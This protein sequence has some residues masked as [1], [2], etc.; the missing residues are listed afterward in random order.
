MNDNGNRGAV[1]GAVGRRFL[2]AVGAGRFNDSGI[3]ALPGVEDD[4][5]RVRALLEKMGYESVLT[6]LAHDPT[7]QDLAAG[8]E[9]WTRRAGLG[10]ED[11]VVVY[12]AGHGECEEDRHYLLCSDSQRDSWAWSLAAEDLARRLVHSEVGHLLVMLDTCFAQAGTTD[13]SRLAMSLAD[14][15]VGRANR[16][17]L[18][19]A[20]TTD[21]AKENLF[22]D[23][24]TE[25]F[26]QPRLG[27]TPPYIGLGEVTRRINAYFEVHRPSQ[28]ARLTA[29]DTDGQDPFFL[30]RHHVP[31]LP[32]D[33]IDLATIA[34][35]RRR[36][37]G[38]F[39]PRS[40]GVEHTGER[41]DYFTGRDRALRELT[42]FLTTP[43]SEHD[44]KARVVTGDP[45][46]GKSALLGRLLQ[47]TD[48]DTPRATT[49]ADKDTG[50]GEGTAPPLAVA[51]VV[52][53]ARR[54]ALGDLV[55]DLASALTLPATADRDDVLAALGERTVPVAVVVDSLDEA[56]TA[57][58]PAESNRIARELLQPLSGLP[59]VRLVVGTRRPQIQALGRAVHV[60]DL[61]HR[62]HIAVGEIAAYARALLEDAQDP[63]S[64]SPY[65]NQPLLAATIAYGIAQRAG[66]S[67][68]VARM[69]ARALVHG[70][71]HIDTTIPDWR[72]QLPS[73]ASEA[74]AAYL[75]RFEG[76]RP[77]VERLLRP[78]AY[79]QGAGLPWSTLWA[80]LAT[81][82][83]GVTCTHEDLDWLHSTAGAYIVETPTADGAVFRLYH[84]TMAEHL[85]RTGHEHHDHAT[86]A[87]TLTNLIPHDPTTGINDWAT[88][89]PYSR[90]HLATHAAAGGTLETLLDD[91]E[92]LVHADPHT[93]Q[94]AIDTTTVAV[95]ITT[96]GIYRASANV[97]A[98]LTPTGR[99]DIL[100]IDAAR[101]QQPH[102]AT[103]LA[104]TR[105]WTPRWATNSLIHQ[106]HR[107]TITGHTDTVNAVAVAELDGRPHAITTSH[108]ETV[109]VWDLT[110]GTPTA[111]LTGHTDLVTAIA[112]AE[113]DGRPHAITTRHDNTVRIWDLTTNTHT[114]TLTG[115]TDL[116]TA[117]AV[118]ELDGRPHA[119]TT[120]HDET[121]RVWDLTT[122][123]T[124]TTF[125]GH[126]RAVTAIAVAE[127]DG[128]PHAITI[129]HDETVQVWDLTTGTTTATLTGHTNADTGV[130]VTELDGRPHAITTNYDNTVRVW[131]LTTNTHTA[132]L[133]GHTRAVTAIAV[134]ELHGQPHAI[135]TSHD[136]TVRIWDLTT[137][138]TITT[139][140]GH[141]NAVSA[142]AV[143]ELDGRPHAITT[144]YDNTVR[145][146]DL[147]TTGTTITTL[148]GHTNWVSAVAVTELDGRPHAITTSYDTTVRVWDLTTGT[149]TATLTGH[150]SVVNGVAVTELDGRPHAI[151]TSFD[152]TV[153]VWDLTTGTT[154][155]TLTGHTSVV[156]GVAVTEL[157]GRPHAI[158]T[159]YDNTARVWDLTTNT[160]TATLTGH[161]D[162]VTAVAVTELHNRPHAITTSNDETVRIWD[163][164]TN[165]TT[166][167]L[168]GHT[169]VMNAVAVTELH[170]RPHTITTSNDETVRIRDLTTNTTTATL[171][172]HTHTVNAIAVTQPHGRP[173]TLT[174]GWDNTVRVWDLHSDRCVAI[175]HLPL[176]GLAVAAHKDQLVI[177]MANEVVVLQPNPRS[178]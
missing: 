93:L 31:G 32:T 147:T 103:R 140:T 115:H 53:H 59:A 117:I 157:D 149:T 74:F 9:A 7:R 42:T 69:T 162:T 166:A 13:I 96:A 29:T 135:T 75:D 145:V 14:M 2:I 21:T 46:S 160:H 51:A 25:L 67:Y 24:L 23:A 86:I 134:T 109:R 30:N 89:H 11:V 63:G 106:A 118:A 50:E 62:E 101:H 73:D 79:A 131:D 10:P 136:E 169:S 72:E 143:T 120:S 132:T 95:D 66:S 77:K 82:L 152:T 64:R 47:L 110:T 163:L 151:T 16:W 97:H 98:Q 175:V 49:A 178:R 133:T 139:L 60:I 22:V 20:R 48:P 39:G 177:G 12:F 144:S 124:I 88:A 43:V 119:I 142:V 141:T 4:V 112:V 18:A 173:H 126:T 1:P 170:G 17:H 99:R 40:R 129:S 121:V 85:R 105:P 158:T 159:S 38:H 128:R 28:Q 130:A 156:N 116:V 68:L 19:A 107:R 113:L 90:D 100:A 76:H 6:E 83:S 138:T 108:D 54:A 171:T 58:D 123:T 167:T 92:Y 172:G 87:T 165:T 57:G 41:G 3:P 36:H 35:L 122:N 15:H 102:L 52:L 111:T 78:L 81:A 84:E 44:R 164:T 5:R 94:R 161:T 45:G 168:T 146:W 55:S 174:T 150:T 8:I 155:A 104:R 70:Q 125:T 153:R 154:T 71:I 80:P 127:L 65:R 114:A 56:G 34:T 61:D 26:D 148:S 176:Q 37:I 137:N 91:P 27:A 33:G